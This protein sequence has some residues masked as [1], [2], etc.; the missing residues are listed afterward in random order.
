MV[1]L[2]WLWAAL[3]SAD[4]LDALARYGERLPAPDPAGTVYDGYRFT[5]HLIPQIMAAAARKPGVVQVERIGHSHAARPIW[6]FHVGEPG[7]E[8]ER[9][10]LV[11]A[12]IHSLEWISTE[13]AV[14]L[15]LELI[16][17]PPRDAR[18]T[19]IPVLNPDGRAQVE[20]DLLHG[21]LDR[22]RRG[23][24]A[25]V[26]LNRNFAVNREPRSFW[27]HI[28]PGY[29]TS[30]GAHALSEP[31]SQALD[32]LVAR[33][34]YDRAASLHAFGGYF[35][36]PWAGRFQRPDDDADFLALGRLM[37]R[38]QVDHAYRPRQLGRWGFFFRAHGAE[39]DHLYGEHGVHAYLVELTRSG[40]GRNVLRDRKIPFRW[41]NPV[42]SAPHRA[43]GVAA[44]RP[45]I[46]ATLEDT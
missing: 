42:D 39:I 44:L 38:A 13:V 46:R 16:E 45:L 22:Y 33:E 41:Y 4:D 35:F 7:S 2:L 28:L 23:N 21:R 5:G 1:W 20:N 12:G 3:A 34:G 30:S 14:D 8:P 40:L 18:V 31:E 25:A 10:V 36:Y 43:R 17:A 9:R 27:R 19:V 15:L 37:E 26:D 11:F 24:G 32:R 29:H 6:A